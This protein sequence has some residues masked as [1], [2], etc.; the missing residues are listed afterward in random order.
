[1]ISVEN[2]SKYFNRETILHDISF[3]LEKGEILGLLGPNGAGKTTL[4]RII[5]QIISADK[6][7]VSYGG[8]LIKEKH[9]INI[10]YLPEERGLYQSMSVEKQILFLGKLRGLSSTEAKDQMEYWLKRFGIQAWRKKRIEELSKGMAQKVQFICTVL[11]EPDVL[12]LDEP[13]SGFDPI[14][15]ELIRK[16]LLNFKKKGKSIIISTHNMNNVEEICDR[17]ILINEGHMVLQ[18]T[19][20]DLRQQFKEDLFKISF[21]GNMISFANALWTGYE[22]IDKEVHSED[23]FTIYLKMRE[24]NKIND[25]LNAV[26]GQVNITGVEEVLPSMENVFVK[27]INA[28]N[29]VLSE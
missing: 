1:M 6:G 10:G 21:T 14:N 22:I 29:E 23:S 2:I 19:I 25:L 5:N 20:H 7:Y 27:S 4:M 18:G 13:F 9:L 17:A 3:S 8:D 16:E 15:I 24:G 11:H 28:Q 26:I 12:I